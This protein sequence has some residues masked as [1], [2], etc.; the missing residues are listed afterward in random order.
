[1]PLLLRGAF[2]ERTSARD[3]LVLREICEILCGP[4]KHE[5]ICQIRPNR[6]QS[7]VL[8]RSNVWLESSKTAS[9][10]RRFWRFWEVLD[11]L[12]PLIFIQLQILTQ[13]FVNLCG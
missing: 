4:P 11:I 6:V 10:A 2:S 3:V 5:R 12:Q 8:L 9:V 13:H 1:M 7:N